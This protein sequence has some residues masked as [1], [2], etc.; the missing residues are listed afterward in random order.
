MEGSQ[1]TSAVCL[2]RYAPN[3]WKLTIGIP[4]IPAS[5]GI[6]IARL[7]NPSFHC[8]RVV[9]TGGGTKSTA[10]DQSLLRLQPLSCLP[11]WNPRA[12]SYQYD[13]FK[14]LVDWSSAWHILRRRERIDGKRWTQHFEWGFFIALNST[15][16]YVTNYTLL[17]IHFPLIYSDKTLLI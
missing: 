12:S 6:L 15:L 14:F 17:Q 5:F 16:R 13:L 9:K 8:Q 2:M 10:L 7:K 11:L 3:V 4:I 1:C